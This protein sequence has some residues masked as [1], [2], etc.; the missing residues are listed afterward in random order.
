MR[1]SPQPAEGGGEGGRETPREA[2][3]DLLL[4][5]TG[6]PIPAVAAVASRGLLGEG[7]GGGGAAAAAASPSPSPSLSPSPSE[8]SPSDLLSSIP[9]LAAALKPALGRGSEA[10]ELAARRLAAALRCAPPGALAAAVS[11]SSV[12]ASSSSAASLSGGGSSS[13]AAHFL[14]P[15]L[16]ALRDALSP[17]PACV[18]LL[19]HSPPDAGVYLPLP[20]L[21][22][23]AAAAAKGTGDEEPPPPP[24]SPVASAASAAASAAAAAAAAAI[25]ASGS[26]TPALPRAPLGT[27]ASVEAYRELSLAARALGAAA[28]SATLAASE[29]SGPSSSSA[30][31]SSALRRLVDAILSDFRSRVGTGRRGFLLPRRRGAGARGARGTRDWQLGA[32]GAAALLA[33]VLTGAAAVILPGCKVGS[34][35]DG[36]LE[37]AVHAGLDDLTDE[38]VWGLCSAAAAAGAGGEEGF[39]PSAA[40]RDDSDARSSS[41]ALLRRD[42]AFSLLTPHDLGANAALLRA[43]AEACGALLAARSGRARGATV[44]RA[45]LPLLELR[46]VRA[47]GGIVGSLASGGVSDDSAGGGGGAPVVASGAAAALGALA[48]ATGQPSVTAAVVA[49]ADFVV[50]GV[51]AR[52]RDGS[53]SGSARRA[54]ALCAAALRAASGVDNSATLRFSSSA[55]SALL[56][57]LAEPARAAVRGLSA[58]A[59]RRSPEAVAPL[60]L[61]LAEICAAAA[62]DA[63]AAAKEAEEASVAVRAEFERLNAA[64]EKREREE[65]EEEEAAAAGDGGDG[66][67]GVAFF[68]ERVRA[69]VRAEERRGTIG[70]SGGEGEGDLGLDR[71]PPG[72]PERPRWGDLQWLEASERARRVAAAAT[73]A[74]AAADVASP[75]LA[76]AIDED[77]DDGKDPSS[78]SSKIALVSLAAAALER[79]LDALRRAQA[80]ADA[81]EATAALLEPRR[82][83]VSPPAPLAPRLLPAV[84]RAWA[85]LAGGALRSRHPPVAARGAACVAALARAAGGEFVSRRFAAEAWPAMRELLDRGR[86]SHGIG[87]AGYT[88][89]LLAPA[90]RKRSQGN[91]K[92]RLLGR[93]SS[94]SAAASGNGDGDGGED[95][96]ETSSA[97]ALGSLRSVRLAV[98]HSLISIASDARA[99][100]C[101][102][103]SGAAVASV[104]SEVAEAAIALASD[105]AAA[106][107]RNAA[108]ALLRALASA[109]GLQGG[110]SDAVWLAL[111][112]AA[113][114]GGSGGGKEGKGSDPPLSVL[115][116]QRPLSPEGFPRVAAVLPPPKRRALPAG[117]S[118]RAAVLLREMERE[119]KKGGEGGA[120]W[121]EKI[122]GELC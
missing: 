29:S 40:T 122:R 34:L 17:D 61:A 85:P 83:V 68:A 55:A 65:E 11:S 81:A 63:D 105:A 15:L 110:G 120:S 78:S 119:E 82:N 48:A 7:G 31:S 2:L 16:D 41:P 87:G 22:E 72:C 100:A 95:D 116:R 75:L 88:G 19:L 32:A 28:A 57:L 47:I 109:K 84:H 89:L 64:R 39:P 49:N 1:P 91:Q 50:D 23:A 43:A 67:P 107:V 21:A 12:P 108:V 14:A 58:G 115:S 79:A 59:R 8:L 117:C 93:S 76:S 80:A 37:A 13:A 101:L 112:Q 44:R 62:A 60:L 9:R 30:S 46:G 96:D 42:P 24:P 4:A 118:A 99:S 6:D 38:A 18:A 114:L 27:V 35:A 52:L 74:D 77:D 121:W 111:A 73:L 94:P 56:P 3:L 71:P 33:E 92:Q 70:D 106:D 25:E 104:A 53:G 102:S 36:E 45:L 103:G 86:T 54:A 20:A 66:S 97:V 26:A 10:G 51:C 5:L 69:R 98:L 113:A 90:G